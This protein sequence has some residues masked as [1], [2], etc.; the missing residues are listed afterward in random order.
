MFYV[1]NLFE[2][3]SLAL[4]W[5]VIQSKPNREDALCQQLL[6]KGLTVYYPWIR[7]TPVNP[8]SRK[9][10]AYFP[11]YLFVNVD[12]EASGASLLQYCPFAKGLVSFDSEPAAVSETLVTAIRQKVDAINSERGHAQPALAPGDRVYIHS[13][14]F[15]G[16]DAIFDEKLSGRERVR[17]LLLLLNNKYQPL[18]LQASQ[19]KPE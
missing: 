19:I 8:R 15:A 7:V 10:K 4:S 5:Y 6:A 3:V 2:D 12:L 13:G 17:V 1:E 14:P 11:S 16:Y 9:N 18:V